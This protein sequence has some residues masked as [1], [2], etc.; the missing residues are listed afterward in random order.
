V[1]KTLT[2]GAAA[3]VLAL[4]TGC[5][6]SSSSSGTSSSASTT[7]ETTTAA[8]SSS[9][10][11]SSSSASAEGEG[12]VVSTAK[13]DLGTYL[14]AGPKHATV[15]L[16][17]ADKAGKSACSGSC[18]HGWPPVTTS[19]KPQASGQAEAADLGTT[20]RSDGTM[21]VTYK[22]HPLYYFVED[23]SPGEAKGE[24]SDAFGAEWYV[25]NA[26]GSKIDNDDEEGGDDDGS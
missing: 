14:V 11:T 12:T 1:T 23:K 13:G 5:G 7:P 17:E 8:P 6:S 2:L 10:T 19:G 24:G 21:Q 16:F 20:E 4:L 3:A 9:A 18:A 25:M 15:Y 26:K 22:G